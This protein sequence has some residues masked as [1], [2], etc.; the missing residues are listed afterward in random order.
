[1]IETFD[2]RS[3][4]FLCLLIL[5][6]F[7]GSFLGVV[8]MRLP[9]GK[10]IVIS[11]SGCP[12]CGAQL[13]AV[14][15]IPL[16]SWLVHPC[17]RYCDARISLFYPVIELCALGIMLW[18]AT[19]TQGYV[20]IASCILG[21]CLL[22]LAFIDVKTLRLPNPVTIGLLA[23]GLTATAIL[24]PCAL[25]AHMVGAILGYGA[26][27][28]VS[29]LYAWVRKQKGLGLGDAKLLAAIG[30]WVSWDGLVSVVLVASTTA[31][32]WVYFQQL[33]K[34][35][36]G[37]LNSVPFGPFLALGGWIVWLYGPLCIGGLGI[38]EP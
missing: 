27:F 23:L 33:C 16:L 12:S 7:V 3:P 26:F 13:R 10:P 22:V 19:Q 32:V 35:N 29:Q 25:P 20:L 31:L 30:A 37:D 17:C 11:R 4:T 36:L 14:D 28:A 8:I 38:C 9:E 2:L 1:M 5:S 18:A 21:W 24:M 15:I 6:P 34:R